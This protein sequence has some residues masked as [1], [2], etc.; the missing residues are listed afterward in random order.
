MQMIIN[1]ISECFSVSRPLN[2]GD[3]PAT[4]P[5]HWNLRCQPANRS[6]HG[7]RHLALPMLGITA[8]NLW[9]LRH[10]TEVLGPMLAPGAVT[11]QRHRTSFPVRFDQRECQARCL[12]GISKGRIPATRSRAT[13]VLALLLSCL[14]QIGRQRSRRDCRSSVTCSGGEHLDGFPPAKSA[15]GSWVLLCTCRRRDHGP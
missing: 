7:T 11:T 12:A 3:C 2:S 6:Q 13:D 4:V 14:G 15:R 1:P 9:K 10:E 8:D 5:L